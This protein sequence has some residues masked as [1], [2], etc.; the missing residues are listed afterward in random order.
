VDPAVAIKSKLAAAIEKMP[1]L[2]TTVTKVISLANDLNSSARDLIT[3]IQLDP[4]LTAKV[5]KLINSAFFALPNKVSLKQAV[6]LLGINTIKN[7]ALSSA[8]IG[9]MGKDRIQVK[10]FDQHRFWAH[11]LGTGIAAK[12]FCR[13]VETDP[14]V[15]EEY[16]V[17]GLIHDIGKIVMALSVPALFAKT[18]MQ[19]ET[20]QIASEEAELKVIGMDHSEVGSLLAR[21]W[22]LSESLTVSILHHHQPEENDG[23]LTWVVHAA[24]CL[25]QRKGYTN[26]GDYS[27]STVH[28]RTFEILK[29]NEQE[30]EGMLAD[31]PDE[32]EK[33]SIFLT[34]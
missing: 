15:W 14:H 4:V 6:V 17:A 10:S 3:V 5:L 9:Y 29:M 22:S 2:P 19:A 25:V 28:P 12:R 16:F 20:Q 34:T 1:S 18:I 26:S 21:K 33:A 31:L 23:R 27:V 7:I 32:I 24:N 8:I 13:K 30:M 11:S